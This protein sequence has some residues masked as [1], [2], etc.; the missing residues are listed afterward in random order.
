M[1]TLTQRMGQLPPA[2][3]KRVEEHAQALVAEEMSLR[4]L[5]RARKQT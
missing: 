2:R 5:R 1:S 4:N 3:R